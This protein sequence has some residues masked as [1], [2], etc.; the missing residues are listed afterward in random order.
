[1]QV[2]SRAPTAAPMP[3]TRPLRKLERWP[4]RQ[5]H[6]ARRSV[7]RDER[8][9]Q[10]EEAVAQRAEQ[11]RGREDVGDVGAAEV[12]ADQQDARHEQQ[13]HRDER[14]GQ[15]GREAASLRAF[16]PLWGEPSRHLGEHEQHDDAA[17]QPETP[18]RRSRARVRG[19]AR[20]PRRSGRR[21][22]WCRGT[23]GSGARVACRGRS[24]GSAPGP[25]IPSG[26]SR[27]RVARARPARRP[28]AG[29]RIGAAG[30]VDTGGP[31]ASGAPLNTSAA[32][33]ARCRSASRRSRGD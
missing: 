6:R 33:S 22:T 12:A 25:S 4:K 32:R 31:A 18:R 24:A 29:S 17:S 8:D 30:R 7:K 26:R 9:R 3:A 14:S 20:A 28:R 15:E 2:G 13:E 11:R 19:C 10:H 16:V 5:S 27:R 23:R 21:R 1:M